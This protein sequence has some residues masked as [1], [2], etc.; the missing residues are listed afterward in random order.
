MI[1]QKELYDIAERLKIQ[2]SVLDK[3]WVLGHFL[4]AMFEI[5]SIRN[6]FVF[7][8]GTCLKKCYFSDYRYSEDLDFTL[9][10]KDFKIDKELIKSIIS[11]AGKK[12]GADF[13]LNKIKQ[14]MY[15]NLPQ[16]YEITI[17]FWGADHK[18]NQAVIPVERWQTKIKLDISFSEKILLQ[19]DVKQI[20]HPYSDFNIINN[21]VF[22]YPINEIISEKIR[23][24]MQRNRPRDIYDLYFLSQKVDKKEYSSIH[25]LLAQKSKDKNLDC[26]KIEN[27]INPVKAR[28]NKRAWESSLGHHLAINKLINFDM[29]YAIVGEL[30]LNIIKKNVT[31][32]QV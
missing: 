26:C 31:I 29:A 2:P 8:G 5:E 23:A 20:F 7:K 18:P 30:V 10:D 6:N 12:S 24:L 16:G 17:A 11:I 13:Y 27:Y 15:N 1:I 9:L 14:Q 32:Q 22:V 3:D 4:N 19:A 21:T 28:K 25:N